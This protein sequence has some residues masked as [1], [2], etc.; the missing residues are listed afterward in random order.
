MLFAGPNGDFPALL[1]A[2]RRG[3][4][5]RGNLEASYER[6]VTLKRALNP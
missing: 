2:A 4:I 5:S 1:D 3:V 6:I